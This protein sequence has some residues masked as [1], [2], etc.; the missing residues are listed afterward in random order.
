MA[1]LAEEVES[2]RGCG[3]RETG[4]EIIEREDQMFGLV[5]GAVGPASMKTSI[6]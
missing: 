1:F 6:C 2:V 3:V 5:F 4:V